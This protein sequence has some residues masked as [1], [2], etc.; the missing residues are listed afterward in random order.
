MNRTPLAP[1]TPVPAPPDPELVIV[2]PDGPTHSP[3]WPDFIPFGQNM[4]WIWHLVVIVSV[5]LLIG[6]AVRLT[7]RRY[8]GTARTAGW[9]APT[10]VIEAIRNVSDS[11]RADVTHAV[12]SVN[13][14]PRQVSFAPLSGSGDSD[15]FDDWADWVDVALENSRDRD[16]VDPHGLPLYETYGL[17]PD[18][19]TV[20]E[21]PAEVIDL[22][23]VRAARS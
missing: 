9:D 3:L 18:T 22:D 2:S 16:P 10:E 21:A 15:P 23:A 12:A 11:Y 6:E 1:A 13:S 8:S 4:P 7:R 20:R 19:A 5:L 17:H 14:G